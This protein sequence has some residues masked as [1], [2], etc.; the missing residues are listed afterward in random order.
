M[1]A[2]RT[3]KGASSSARDPAESET[4]MDMT[5]GFGGGGQR[6]SAPADHD[7]EVWKKKGDTFARHA[8][9]N[10]AGN[11]VET[12]AADSGLTHTLQQSATQKIVS[13]LDSGSVST[14][15]QQSATQKIV[16]AL[17]SGSVSTTLQLS[18]MQK[19]VST[20]DSGSACT[21]FT[22]G[23]QEIKLDTYD[24]MKAEPGYQ[25]AQFRKVWVLKDGFGMPCYILATEPHSP[26]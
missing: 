12:K 18:A 16:S 15:L 19:I 20:V 6:A 14:T 25:K 13:A 26:T 1:K 10:T 17:A 7:V 24:L 21:I 23:N 3:R 5:T 11:Y 9:K 22:D 2:P 8:I 4:G